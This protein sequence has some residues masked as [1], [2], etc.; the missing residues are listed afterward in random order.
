MKWF[1]LNFNLEFENWYASCK[2]IAV[3]WKE[4]SKGDTSNAD[5]LSMRGIL[6]RYSLEPRPNNLV[7]GTAGSVMTIGLSINGCSHSKKPVWWEKRRL[8]GPEVWAAATSKVWRESGRA[9]FHSSLKKTKEAPLAGCRQFSYSEKTSEK[10]FHTCI[11]SSNREN[12]YQTVLI[13]LELIAEI[14]SNPCWC[15]AVN[16]NVTVLLRKWRKI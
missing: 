9:S 4:Q 10:Y 6:L 12:S 15:A 13:L 1:F 7:I 8:T 5:G 3:C 16:A 2:E 11:S 14:L